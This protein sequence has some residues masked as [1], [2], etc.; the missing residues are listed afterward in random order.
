MLL[1]GAYAVLSG[2]SLCLCTPVFTIS[3]SGLKKMSSWQRRCPK[4]HRGS[5][6]QPR[7]TM[8]LRRARRADSGRQQVAQVLPMVT[9]TTKVMTKME[10]DGFETVVHKRNSCAEYDGFDTVATDA[11]VSDDV[12]AVR[13]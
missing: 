9:D 12:K 7:L 11:L 3:A 2:I 8:M 4:L 5:Q 10:Y 1:G 13:L 6:L